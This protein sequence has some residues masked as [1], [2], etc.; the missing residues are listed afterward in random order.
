ME[1]DLQAD[2]E[3]LMQIRTDTLIRNLRL[4]RVQGLVS[5]LIF[6]SSKAYSLKQEWNIKVYNFL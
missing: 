5:R 1:K 2:T 3:T 4:W 6:I